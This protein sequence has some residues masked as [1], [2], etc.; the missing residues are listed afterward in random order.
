MTASKEPPIPPIYTPNTYEL[1]WYPAAWEFELDATGATVDTRTGAV[2]GVRDG[3][4][5]GSKEG[6]E[7]EGL[8]EGIDVDGFDEGDIVGRKEGD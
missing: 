4:V 2:D 8:P 3:A 5:V 7:E 6:V 1:T